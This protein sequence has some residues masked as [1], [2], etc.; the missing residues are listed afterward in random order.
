MP[1]SLQFVRTDLGDGATETLSV[2]RAAEDDSLYVQVQSGTP[3]HLGDY[4]G[5]YTL[6]GDQVRGEVGDFDLVP[7][8]RLPAG[9]EARQVAETLAWEAR[10]HG[11][12]AT[13]ADYLAEDGALLFASIFEDWESGSRTVEAWL[14]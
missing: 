4:L 12:R 8:D 11:A 1:Q 2:V 9:D 14:Q 3:D 6:A 7:G 13:T 5:L 10:G